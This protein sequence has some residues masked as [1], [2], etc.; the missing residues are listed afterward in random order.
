MV[1]KL[2]W[3]CEQVTACRLMYHNFTGFS[4]RLRPQCGMTQKRMTD[5][6]NPIK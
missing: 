3:N 2:Y 5:D 1:Y 4:E 6:F